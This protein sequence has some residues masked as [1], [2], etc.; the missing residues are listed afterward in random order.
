MAEVS[1]A[2]FTEWLGYY[3]IEPFGA[4]ID[5]LRAGVI[6]A[7][8]YN[9]HRDVKKFPK[10]LGPVDVIGWLDGLGGQKP[11]EVDPIVLDDPVA[12]TNLLRASLFGKH[13]HAQADNGREP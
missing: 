6:A 1:S 11:E 8:T 3:Q 2:E 4:R 5:D 7:A 13:T 9:V 12:Q 10:A